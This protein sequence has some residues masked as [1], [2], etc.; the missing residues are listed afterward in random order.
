M[1]CHQEHPRTLSELREITRRHFFQQCGVGV[2]KIAL[3]SMLAKS[4]TSGAFASNAIQNPQS[5][6]QNPLAVKPPHFAA[7]AKRVIYLFQVGAPSQLDLFDPKP[8]LAKF[9]GQPIPS[10]FVKDQ[11]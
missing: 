2:G 10:D 9:D 11:R 7:K 1:P 5:K 8:T 6:I 4:M 3:A